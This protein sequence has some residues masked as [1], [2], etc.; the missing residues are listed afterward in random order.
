MRPLLL[1]ILPFALAACGDDF[2]A[3]R[4]ECIEPIKK[5]VR[6]F[7]RGMEPRT[8]IADDCNRYEVR[9]MQPL[10]LHRGGW[11]GEKLICKLPED[12]RRD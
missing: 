8:E 7:G 11:G 1:A 4:K 3:P 12:R 5:E 10:T 9:C 6:V 2:S